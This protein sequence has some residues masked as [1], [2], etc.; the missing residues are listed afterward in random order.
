MNSFCGGAWDVGSGLRL[1]LWRKGLSR[2]VAT[3]WSRT[4]ARLYTRSTFY[5]ICSTVLSVVMSIT[6]DVLLFFSFAVSRRA[7]ELLPRLWTPCRTR[8]GETK[9]LKVR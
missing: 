6:H 4:Y 9:P 8:T 3:V 7:L 2:F 5:E 1:R